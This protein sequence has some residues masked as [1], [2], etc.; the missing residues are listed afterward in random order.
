MLDQQQQVLAAENPLNDIKFKEGV[1]AQEKPVEKPVEKP[2][3][4][5]AQAKVQTTAKTTPAKGG[6]SK[7]RPYSYQQR[8]K[9]N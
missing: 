9:K 2:S 5:P 7:R 6:S 4:A 3:P 1:K 8:N